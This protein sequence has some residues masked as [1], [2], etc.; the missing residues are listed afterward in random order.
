VVAKRS[1]G[2]RSHERPFEVSENGGDFAF[3]LSGRLGTLRGS[4]TLTVLMPG[5]TADE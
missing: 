1:R 4:G 2:T 3:T 5:L